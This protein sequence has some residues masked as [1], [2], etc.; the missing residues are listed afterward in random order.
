MKGDDPLLSR[1]G[2]RRAQET[3]VINLH[4]IVLK[5]NIRLAES[6][7]LMGKKREKRKRG[8]SALWGPPVRDGSQ[9]AI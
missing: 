2:R 8:A 5:K 1:I 3:E 6:Q 7:A 9:G 4:A